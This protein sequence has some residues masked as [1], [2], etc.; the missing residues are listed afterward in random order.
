M[1]VMNG[2]NEAYKTAE[3][4]SVIT[5]LLFSDLPAEEKT[6][7]RVQQETMTIIGAGIDTTRNALTVAT[8]HLLD[9]PD[10]LARLRAE[11]NASFPDVSYKPTWQEL[12]KLPFLTAV[13]QECK[14]TM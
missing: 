1:N 3:H 7:D 4:K 5:S 13:I 11:L 14:F 9:K 10:L 8:F 6:L 2:Q 12:E